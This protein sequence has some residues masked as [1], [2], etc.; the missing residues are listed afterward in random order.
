MFL[1]SVVIEL[2]TRRAESTYLSLFRLI[3]YAKDFLDLHRPL[4]SELGERELLVLPECRSIEIVV[5]ATVSS[6]VIV[7]S[8]WKRIYDD[9]LNFN[10]NVDCSSVIENLNCAAAP[11]MLQAAKFAK[12]LPITN[13]S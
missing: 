4:K 12:E 8:F 10:T 3:N 6:L 11:S 2:K 9:F 13:I 7:L 1:H 5:A